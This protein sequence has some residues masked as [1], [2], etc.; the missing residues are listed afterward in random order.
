MNLGVEE[1]RN[2]LGGWGVGWGG[3]GELLCVCV[4]VSKWET[5]KHMSAERPI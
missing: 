1:L 4:E 5:D 2:K 3:V